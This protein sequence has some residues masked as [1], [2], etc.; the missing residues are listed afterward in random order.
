MLR[1]GWEYPKTAPCFIPIVCASEILIIIN[2]IPGP[3]VVVVMATVAVDVVTRRHAVESRSVVST[4][5][6]QRGGII[7]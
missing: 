5:E 1:L 6:N 3:I 2:N 7:K 4:S